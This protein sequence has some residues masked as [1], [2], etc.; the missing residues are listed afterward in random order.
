MG[1]SP[2]PCVV[3]NSVN[4]ASQASHALQGYHGVR[5]RGLLAGCRLARAIERSAT[6][7][8]LDREVLLRMRVKMRSRR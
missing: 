8:R 5:A 1:F 3:L 4:C 2:E 7:V 6:R